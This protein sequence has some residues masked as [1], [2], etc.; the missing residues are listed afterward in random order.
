MQDLVRSGH[1]DQA[2]HTDRQRPGDRQ[3]IVAAAAR[4]MFLNGV[5]NDIG[6]ERLHDIPSALLDV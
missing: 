4:L 3:R 2:R 6:T 1:A 5:A